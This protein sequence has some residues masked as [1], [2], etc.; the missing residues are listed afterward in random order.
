M[1]TI[2]DARH[3]EGWPDF[4]LFR[5][6]PPRATL[7]AWLREAHALTRTLTLGLSAQQRTVPLLPIVNPP[8]WEVGH[9]AW[10]LEFWMHRGGDF[11]VPCRRPGGD[12]LYDSARVPHD[13]RWTLDLPAWDATH[14]YLQSVVDDT[15]ERIEARPLDDE[16]AYFIQLS[17]AHHDMHNEA[18]AYM[19]QTL[20]FPLPL[21][22]PRVRVTGPCG[23]EGDVDFPA[24]TLT[25]GARPG[26]GFVHDNEKWAHEVHVPAFSIARHA[27]T[28][29]QFLAFVEDGGYARRDLWTGAGWQMREGLGLAHPRYWS[30][31]EG[32]WHLRRHDRVL[33]LPADEPVM[34]V[35]C[36]EAEAYCRWA[37]RRLPTEAEW[38]RA[39]SA[40][41]GGEG[42][43]AYPWGAAMP[44]PGVHAHCDARAGG[45][46]PVY[47]CPAGLSAHGVCQMIGNAWEWTSTRFGPYP[48]FSPDPY[49]EYSAPWFAD[50]H[51]VLRGG[52]FFTP[53]R[54]VR[55]T[56][57]NFYRPDRADMFCGFRT[58]AR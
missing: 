30:R 14:V 48:G 32:A 28:N 2:A 10:F 1:A 54:L 40:A 16:T 35:S 24:A 11:A 55:N 20:G 46:G 12:R 22:A 21:A 44:E 31:Q 51:R 4:A 25:L 47:D 56:W 49:R 52:S 27:T 58:C 29:A 33:P 34:H 18:F 5:P 39:A 57:R 45:P 7:V 41:P 19:W 38:E 42:K 36:H 37:G 13:S 17:I 6:H 50:E 43:R 3:R 53:R 9:V 15:V 23:S 26:E 8:A